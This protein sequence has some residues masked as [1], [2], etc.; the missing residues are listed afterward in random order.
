MLVESN[1]KKTIVIA[2]DG[3]AGVG[4]STVARLVAQHLQYKFI[5]S[6]LLYRALAWKTLKTKTNTDD[7]QNLSELARKIKWDFKTNKGTVLK[8]FIDDVLVYNQVR[9]EKVS[10]ISSL[11]SKYPKVRSVIMEKLRY[12]GSKYSIV[13]EG[14]D[15]ATVVFPDAKLKIFLDASKTLRAK[16]RY[17][18]LIR[19][20]FRADY[21]EILSSIIERDKLDSTRE[22][23]PLKKS[24]DSVCIDTSHLTVSEV[25]NKILDLAHKKNVH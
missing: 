23:S 17:T 5:N 22:I 16:R 21:E 24:E 1:Y 6:G 4:K 8:L 20:G 9:S 25:V 18:Q 10:R 14:R 3:P 15:I 13:M 11:I 19:K 12:L 7:E 2:I